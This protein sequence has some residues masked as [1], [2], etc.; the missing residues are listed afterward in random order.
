MNSIEIDKY[1]W[2]GKLTRYTFGDWHIRETPSI[3]PYFWSVIVSIL[4]APIKYA[5]EEIDSWGYG[6]HVAIGIGL[7]S[8][9]FGIV[10]TP[11]ITLMI[12]LIIVPHIFL[13]SY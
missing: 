1:S 4:G 11:K 2:H 8:M 5:G 9:F 12:G 7:S 10:Y 3:C 6:L 13:D